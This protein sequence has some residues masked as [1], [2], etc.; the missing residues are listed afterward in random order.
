[1]KGMTPDSSGT[2]SLCSSCWMWRRL[3]DN[4]APQ[5]INELVCD[6]TD[7]SCLSGY[8]TCGVGHRA[9]EVVR[10]DSGVVTTVAL[11]AGSYCECRAAY[12]SKM[13]GQQRTTGQESNG[14]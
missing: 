7:S 6:T 4:Y 5:Y 2:V 3:P 12:S 11:S 14:L 8:A 13:T 10:N 9:V 1:M